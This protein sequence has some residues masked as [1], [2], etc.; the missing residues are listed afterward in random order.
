MQIDPLLA[1]PFVPFRTAEKEKLTIL[2]EHPAWFEKL[3]AELDR[4]EIPYSKV[5]AP[6]SS[7]DPGN[8][9]PPGSVLFNR[10]SPSAYK[11]EHGSGI[12]YTLAYLGDT[13]LKGVRVVN[14]SKA[15]RYE[16]SKALLPHESSIV[17]EM[18]PKRQKACAFLLS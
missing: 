13:E 17:P 7:F 5:F 14:G 9:Y 15:Y 8:T 3:F 11:R 4:R 12:F 18:L 16:L 1:E 10:M 2:Y 6:G